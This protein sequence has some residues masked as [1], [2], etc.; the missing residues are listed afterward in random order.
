MRNGPVGGQEIYK[1][2]REKLL[3]KLSA[4]KVPCV[5]ILPSHPEQIRNN[6]VHHYYRQDSS[7]F[8]LTGHTE[9]ET[10]MVLNPAGKNKFI[11]FVRE[12]D[13]TRELWDGF[14]YGVEGAAEYFGADQV[15]PVCEFE[16]VMPEILK[17][18]E[19]V[20]YRLNENHE[21]DTKVLNL[22]QVAKNLNGRS[23]L[24]PAQVSDLKKVVGEM[25][26]FKTKEELE[27][28]RK[29]C[30]I[31]AAGHVAAMKFLKPNVYE[32]QVQAE[33]EAEF[34]RL[35]A[36]RLGYE[37]IVG[38]G[39]NATVLHYISNRDQCK[40][41]D[42]L[43]IDAGAEYNYMTG[44]ITRVS[45]INGKFSKDQKRFYDAVLK[46]QK[47]CLKMIKPGVRFVDI[48]N[49]AIEGL[50]IEMLEL[51]L[52]KGNVKNLIAKREFFKYF[53]HGTGHWLGMDVHDSGLYL[54]NGESR[55]LEPGM[56]FTV[57]P[58][59]YVPLKDKNAPKEYRGLGVRIE[60]NVHVTPKGCEV[61]T[62]AAPKEVEEI[63][64]LMNG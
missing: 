51:G 11:L 53:P 4:D 27:Y 57:E 22:L 5:A 58:G 54:I 21:F 9:P 7:L 47:S 31:S 43:L 12:K 30:N 23:G 49:H 55:Q 36:E 62:T 20:Y 48:H 64:L 33:V 32:Y 10:I 19:K 17:P 41:G 18:A 15:Y 50:T 6:D 46:V 40:D 13:P 8:Y 60:D 14:R 29:A 3:A 26:L 34:K 16:T 52:L 28:L 42:L 2:R 35:G 45:P 38:S 24:G 37:S 59:L 25:R 1:K 61:M 39:A 44:D 56:C 63:E